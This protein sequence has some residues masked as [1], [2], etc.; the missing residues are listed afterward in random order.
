MVSEFAE[1]MASADEDQE[2]GFFAGC[3]L[4]LT[5][6]IKPNWLMNR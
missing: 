3:F 6:K 5:L 1:L 4:T 2:G